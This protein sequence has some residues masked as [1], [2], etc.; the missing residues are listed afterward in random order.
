MTTDNRTTYALAYTRNMI[1]VCV[2]GNAK[3]YATQAVWLY[4]YNRD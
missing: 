3:L 1:L 4:V 2:K